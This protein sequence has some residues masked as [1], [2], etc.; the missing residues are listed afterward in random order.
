MGRV[1]GKVALVTGGA[2]GLGE[3]CARMMAREG[4][5]V[6]L[7]DL[8]V[9]LAKKVLA[10]IEAAGG[11]GMTFEMDVTQEE[12]WERLMRTIRQQYG[13]LNVIVNS[14]GYNIPRSFP[15][16]TTLQ[17]WRELMAV[18]L[19]GVFLGTK[20]AIALMSESQPVNGSVIN[21]SSILGLVATTD[22]AAYSASKGAVRLYGKSVALSCAE[23]KLNIRVNSVHPGFID[24]P[25]LRKSLERFPDLQEARKRYDALAP[26]GHL[27]HAD[28]IAYG[29]LYLASDES[30]FVTGS[31]LVIDGGYTCQ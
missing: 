23:R 1:A 15:S 6:I 25:L 30:R 22:N 26:V 16:E 18:N 13:Q 21:I 8:N 28:D 12:H 20:H 27:G 31:E 14:A 10:E 4:A 17:A 29:V 2:S 9:D 24:T 19:D 11:E 5:R 3:A 7:A